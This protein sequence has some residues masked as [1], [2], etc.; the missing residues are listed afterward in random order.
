MSTVAH[1][2]VLPPIRGSMCQC[3]RL[4]EQRARDA[5]RCGAAAHDVNM[6]ALMLQRRVA[7]QS[8]LPVPSADQ[9]VSVAHLV[10]MQCIRASSASSSSSSSAPRRCSSCVTGR[11]GHVGRNRQGVWDATDRVCGTQRTGC[12]GCDGRGTT[13]GRMGRDGQGAWESG[14]DSGMQS[15]GCMRVWHQEFKGQ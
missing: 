14:R 13:V 7:Q 9:R 10:T 5:R 15:H 6:A 8:V 4:G 1:Q 12:V 11:V 2:S 3:Q